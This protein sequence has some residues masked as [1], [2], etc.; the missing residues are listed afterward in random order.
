MVTQYIFQYTNQS[1]VVIQITFLIEAWNMKM[2]II[3]PNR[4]IPILTAHSHTFITNVALK[5]A[6]FQ[7][8]HWYVTNCIVFRRAYFTTLLTTD[9]TA[10]IVDH[11]LSFINFTIRSFLIINVHT[12][13]VIFQRFLLIESF[14]ADGTRFT[15]TVHSFLVIIV[16]PTAI[17]CFRTVC[18][19][20]DGWIDQ[21]SR[22]TMC[23]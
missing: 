3:Q 1:V 15:F 2:K 22:F 16:R 6:N 4:K 9:R 21:V 19:L 12:L 14:T 17:K 7:M 18:A 13:H 8:D 10:N 11:R 20:N 23:R 5:I